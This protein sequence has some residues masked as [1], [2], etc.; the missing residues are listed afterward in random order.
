MLIPAGRS[1]VP[2]RYL[3]YIRTKTAKC[4]R[5]TNNGIPKRCGIGNAGQ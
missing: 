3:K 1:T 4:L 2:T 5:R